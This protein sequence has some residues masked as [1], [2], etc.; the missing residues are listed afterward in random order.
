MALQPRYIRTEDGNISKFQNRNKEL[1]QFENMLREPV[2][3]TEFSPTLVVHGM[4]GNG[5]SALLAKCRKIVD[6]NS[7]QTGPYRNVLV[8]NFQFSNTEDPP[9]TVEFLLGL[10]EVLNSCG[11]K[12]LLFDWESFCIRNN[13]RK[14]ASSH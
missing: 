7:S 4:G 11:L 12:T 10:R 13:S 6:R 2:Q 9:R 1:R 5:K 8:S 14:M 3:N